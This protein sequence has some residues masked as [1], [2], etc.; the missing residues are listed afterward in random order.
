MLQLQNI[1]RVIKKHMQP[2]LTVLPSLKQQ[3]TLWRESYM[4]DLVTIPDDRKIKYSLR[5]LT[6]ATNYI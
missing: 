6:L 2:F 4:L 5:D 1:S 3:V